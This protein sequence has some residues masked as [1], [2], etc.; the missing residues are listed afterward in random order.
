MS[1]WVYSECSNEKS[2]QICYMHRIVTEG[3]KY[4]QF[5]RSK[6]NLVYPS[7]QK[8]LRKYFVSEIS[9]GVELLNGNPSWYYC[10]F[11]GEKRHIMQQG[12]YL[13]NYVWDIFCSFL[14][15]KKDENDFSHWIHTFSRLLFFHISFVYLFIFLFILAEDELAFSPP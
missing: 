12:K 2:S 5:K 13:K 15:V 7:Y 3:I 11:I 6:A 14:H 10:I 8:G 1:L 4:I 9:S